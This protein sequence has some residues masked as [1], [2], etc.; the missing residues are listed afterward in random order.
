ME[1][2]SVLYQQYTE[3][4]RDELVPAMGCTEPISIAYAAAKCRALLGCEPE[5][6]VL[7]VSSSIIKNVKSVIVPNTGGRKGI[8]TAV[9]AGIVGGDETAQLQ[10]LA[11]MQP[12]QIDRIE[13][14]LKATPILVKHAQNGIMFYIDITVWGKGHTARLAISHHHTNI[15]RIEKDGCVLLDKTEDASAQSVS[16]DRSVLSVEGIWDYVNSVALEDVSDAISRQIDYNSALAKEGLTNRWGAQIGRITQQ[17]SN[18]DVRMLARA[19]AA[20]GSDARM[21]GC[22]LPAV[23]LSGSGNQGIT[24]TMPVLVY[25]EHLGSTHEQLYRA[26]VLSDLVT[27][28]QKTGIGSVS[29]F[30]GAVCAGVGAGCGIAYL[31]G[32]DYD[33]ICH[34]IVNAL[35]ILSGMLCDGAK[36][37]CAAKISAAV[38]AGIMGYTMYASGQQFYGGDGIVKKGV[39]RSISSVCTV[40]RDG[41]RETNDLILEVMLQK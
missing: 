13:D 4:L 35:A 15:I 21:N 23:I 10:V 18:G 39:E 3:I 17:Q 8:E 37:S 12:A 9:A 27:I 30:C 16:A 32:A 14:Y 5:R 6:C 2:N 20:A 24:A 40:A 28:H 22:E 29:A 7:E 33:V 25:A 34:T 41:M 26:L 1:R 36:S 11:H 19:A 31:Q 38:D